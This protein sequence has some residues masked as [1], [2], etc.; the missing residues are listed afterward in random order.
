[1]R[2]MKMKA[3]KSGWIVKVALVG[4][5]F[6]QLSYGA[7]PAT[8]TAGEL[9]TFFTALEQSNGKAMITEALGGKTAPAASVA[10]FSML[11][12]SV[13]AKQ[14]TI[15]ELR[16]FVNT[17]QL[18]LTVA[19]GAAGELVKSNKPLTIANLTK[20]TSVSSYVDAVAK[21]QGKAVEIKG[22]PKQL[23]LATEVAG[24]GAVGAMA[25]YGKFTPTTADASARYSKIA[26][27]TDTDCKIEQQ[28]VG[29]VV[30][31]STKACAGLED[32]IPGCQA[33]VNQSVN[34]WYTHTYLNVV[35]KEK[36]AKNGVKWTAG[37]YLT[38]LDFEPK[39]II[40][41]WSAITA[42][43]TLDPNYYDKHPELK[44]CVLGRGDKNTAP[45]AKGRR[46]PG[47]SEEVPAIAP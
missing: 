6:G 9:A 20:T 3:S 11:Q 15:A 4:A 29:E 21:E 19:L 40:E 17:K 18:N 38:K 10:A 22:L 36:D 31:A 33:K 44:L 24:V 32:V 23:P 27:C 30:A 35:S 45:T 37:L 12:K 47:R 34:D 8:K 14:I 46:A 5:L 42:A 1:M 25:A 43:A 39:A 41:G 7:N 26:N 13:A 2:K 16:E 28:D